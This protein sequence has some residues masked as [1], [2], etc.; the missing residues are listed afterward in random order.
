MPMHVPKKKAEPDAT[1][2]ELLGE[3]VFFFNK[4]EGTDVPFYTRERALDHDDEC[5]CLE[6]EN[7]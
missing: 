2:A 3:E 1:F 6:C 5:E 7:I 4:D